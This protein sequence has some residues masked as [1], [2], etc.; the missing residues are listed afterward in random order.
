VKSSLSA[1][2]EDYARQAKSEFIMS[3]SDACAG[4]AVEVFSDADDEGAIYEGTTTAG[5]AGNWM[6]NKPGGF[7][8]PYLTATAT[9]A[10]GSSSGFSAPAPR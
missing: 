3:F 1:S 6:L 5:A 2:K 8:G 9:D 4:F 10:A 7:S